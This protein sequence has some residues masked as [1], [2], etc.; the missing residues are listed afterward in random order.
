MPGR[1]QIYVQLLHCRVCKKQFSHD[2]Y[3][4]APKKYCSYQCAVIAKTKGWKENK[5]RRNN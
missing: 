3:H 2:G 1:K 5:L 4:S